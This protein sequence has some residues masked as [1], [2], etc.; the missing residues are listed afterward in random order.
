MEDEDGEDY[1]GD[2]AYI[3]SNDSGFFMTVGKKNEFVYLEQEN[4]NLVYAKMGQL[5]LTPTHSIIEKIDEPEELS[6][7]H[8]GPLNDGVTKAGREKLIND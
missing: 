3:I 1:E 4:I 8:I 2:D 6:K 5:N 7:M